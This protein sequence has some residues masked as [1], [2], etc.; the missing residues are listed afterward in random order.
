MANIK[1]SSPPLST[2]A[3]SYYRGYCHNNRHVQTH[4]NTAD[5]PYTTYMYIYR[6]IYNHKMSCMSAP[7]SLWNLYNKNNA[8]IYTKLAPSIH[9]LFIY[10][11]HCIYVCSLLPIINIFLIKKHAWYLQG[12]N[13]RFNAAV[14]KA[15]KK[16]ISSSLYTSMWWWC[17]LQFFPFLFVLSAAAT[18]CIE[19]WKL[20]WVKIIWT[21][22]RLVEWR[23][24]HM[25][26]GGG[27]DVHN[28]QIKYAVAAAPPTT[29]HYRMRWRKNLLV[30]VSRWGWWSIYTIYMRCDHCVRST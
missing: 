14:E 23:S 9:I 19:I 30:C 25:Q 12:S 29:T 11:K 24:S 28:I 1:S 5:H 26:R 10:N 20:V 15:K 6:C 18:E 8:R 27:M 13:I 21:C 16:K 17:S 7:I 22:A 3:Y 4:T 2:T